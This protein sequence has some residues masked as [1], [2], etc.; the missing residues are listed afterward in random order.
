VY[1]NRK[2]TKK[3]IVYTTSLVLIV[4]MLF[5]II[6]ITTLLTFKSQSV[7]DAKDTLR[8]NLNKNLQSEVLFYAKIIKRDMDSRK[9][10]LFTLGKFLET[11][12]DSISEGGYA[13]AL[14]SSY[15]MVNESFGL[16][17]LSI[18]D[19]NFNKLCQYPQETD[20]S[21]LVR[22]IKSQ[23]KRILM[24]TKR[25]Q[26]IDFHINKD[27]SV[28]YSYIYSFKDKDG[29]LLFLI[30][31]FQ[32]YSIYS[33]AKTAQVKPYSQKYLW[34]INKNGVLIFDPPTAKH[35][36]ITLSDNVDLKNKQNG[37]VLSEIVKN[38]I[39]KGKS[40]TSRYI[41]RNVDKFVG[42]T[43]IKELGWGLGLTLPTKEFYAPILNLSTSIDKKTIYAISVLSILSAFIIIA[44]AVTSMFVSKKITT[45]IVNAVETINAI[46]EGDVSKR[47]PEGSGDE[48]DEMAQSIN[49]LMDFFAKLLSDMKNK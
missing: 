12:F 28:S 32:P 26:Y 39:L 31:D 34:I 8:H 37:E 49:K 38:D 3:I 16:R 44:T 24:S 23:K 27:K 7:K 10:T 47:L 19:G 46:L 33:L 21:N 41:F 30:F 45:P 48:L 43:Y 9:N 20:V 29:N 11:K 25:I 2:L 35:P 5:S 42:Y 18:I 1:K 40:G 36:L 4:V 14:Q 17:S 22:I 15:D 13:S 6:S